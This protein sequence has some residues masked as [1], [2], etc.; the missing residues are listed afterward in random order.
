AIPSFRNAAGNI[1]SLLPD[2]AELIWDDKTHKLGIHFGHSDM[3]E[4]NPLRGFEP[5]FMRPGENAPARSAVSTFNKVLTNLEP[6]IAKTGANADDTA[7]AIVRSL[8]IDIS[9][10]NPETTPSSKN[11]FWGSVF[12]SIKNANDRANEISKNDYFG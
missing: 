7:K 10:Q 8:A 2:D 4:W 11:T 5:P 9:G 3:S 12:D 1:N 6:I